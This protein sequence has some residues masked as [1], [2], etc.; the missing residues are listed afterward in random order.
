[1][2]LRSQAPRQN[3]RSRHRRRGELGILKEITISRLYTVHTNNDQ[4]FSLRMSFVNV[5]CS[6]S[7]QQLGI[8]NGVNFFP[9][10]SACQAL[11]LLEND[12]CLDVCIVC[13][14]IGSLL[15]FISNKIMENYRSHMTEDVFFRKS[16]MNMN[17]TAEIYNETLIITRDFC[18]KINKFSIN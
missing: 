4:C 12:R 13:N 9:F 1:M 3:V 10:R 8:I 17:F 15:S 6:T 2:R 7:F 5:L 18:F 14:H 11:N 16:N